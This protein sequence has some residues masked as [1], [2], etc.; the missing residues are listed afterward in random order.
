[1]IYEA[2]FPQGTYEQARNHL[3][4]HVRENQLQEDL[5][6]GLWNP[7]TGQNR[8]SAI[9][10]DII[11]P[12]EGDR[13]LNGNAAFGPEYLSRAIRLANDRG[14]GLAFMHNHFTPG[15]Q[16]M[17]PEDIVAERDRIAPVAA[18]TKLPLVGLTM[19]TDGSMSARFWID[20]DQAKPAWCHK[21]RFMENGKMGVTYNSTILPPYQRRPQLKRT[22]DSWGWAMQEKMARLRI[23]V[24]G[25]GSVGAIVIESLARM[26]VKTLLLIDADKVETHNLDR[27][28][29]ASPED[30]N[31]Y[32]VKIAE[33]HARRAATAENFQVISIAGNL[34]NEACYR[35][36]LDCDLLFSCVDH[37]LPKDLLNHIAYAHCIPVI[38]GGIF[39]DNKT[40]RRLAQANWS[41][42]VIGPGHQCLRC[43]GQ[44]TTSE[45][46]QEKDGTFDDPEYLKTS[47]N[48]TAPP[49]NQNVFPLSAH[50]A[51]AM[52]LEMVRYLIAEDW[53]PAKSGKVMYSFI[54]DT[55][56]RFLSLCKPHCIVHQRMAKGDTEPYPFIDS[57]PLSSD[58]MPAPGLWTKILTWAKGIFK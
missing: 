24:V 48:G 29:H 21:V 19:G 10:A 34:Q 49:R 13:T 27:L 51:S 44:Y 3:L 8:Y 30:V 36:A 47:S 45:V 20:R 14:M 18:S 25:V 39:L 12:I 7:S 57:S 54:P 56:E 52:V 5:C 9:I 37:P 28:L 15:W 35:A 43:D 53:W 23:G 46:V 32:K 26:G 41:A 58:I 50:L 6:F 16:D 40:N 31:S 38:F 1:M 22:I 33:K 55:Q 2:V 4:Q 17:S 42:S 11:E